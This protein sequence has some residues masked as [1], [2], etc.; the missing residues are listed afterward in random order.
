MIIHHNTGVHPLIDVSLEVAAINRYEY[1]R[2][3]IQWIASSI[4]TKI[5][6]I[7][8]KQNNFVACNDLIC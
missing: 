2:I 6:Q 7:L 8:H 5:L 1:T 3:L 4:Y